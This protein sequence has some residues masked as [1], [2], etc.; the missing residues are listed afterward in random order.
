MAIFRPFFG[1]SRGC[2]AKKRPKFC[3]TPQVFCCAAEV[4]N[5]RKAPLFANLRHRTGKIL[6]LT[7]FFRFSALL[8]SAEKSGFSVRSA[9]SVFRKGRF[10]P[11]S[12]GF[13]SPEKGSIFR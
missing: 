7:K 9:M 2:E 1:K 4:A 11:V 3:Q 13:E 8:K 10:C 5:S 6:P 12:K